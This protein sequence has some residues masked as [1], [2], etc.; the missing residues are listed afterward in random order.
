MIR[1][2]T[3]LCALLCLFGCSAQAKCPPD[4]ITQQ[5]VAAGEEAPLASPANPR[6][7]EVRTA[8][9]APHKTAPHG[10]ASITL[11]AQGDK[12]FVGRLEVAAGAAVPEHQDPTEEYI[13]VLSGRGTLTMDGVSYEVSAGATI[14][15]PAHATVSFQNGDEPLVAIQVFAGPGPAEKYNTWQ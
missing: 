1:S 10:K 9:A 7:G 14:F 2:I 5:A 3:R 6:A 12:A 15:M 4:A 8:E 11:L 13:H